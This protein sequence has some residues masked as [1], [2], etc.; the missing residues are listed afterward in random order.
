MISECT[1]RI[2]LRLPP[3]FDPKK[4]EKELSEI[5][6]TKPPYDADVSFY[7]ILSGPGWNCPDYSDWLW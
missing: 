7:N 2:S 3:T 4:A 6:T 5:L 1:A